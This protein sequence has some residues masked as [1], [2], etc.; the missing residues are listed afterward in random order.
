[1]G[2]N[3]LRLDPMLAGP[4]AASGERSNC[5]A[6]WLLSARSTATS[7]LRHGVEAPDLR[8]LK[9]AV[10]EFHA[11]IASANTLSRPAYERRKLHRLAI[12]VI[13]PYAL[14]FDSAR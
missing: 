2:A 3:L 6:S 13:L 5:T 7:Q 11:A 10:K 14:E 12:G 4:Q 9:E 8:F 1:M